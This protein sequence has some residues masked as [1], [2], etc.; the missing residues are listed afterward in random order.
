MLD[1][2]TDT[3][4]DE[5]L[6]KPD[7]KAVLDRTNLPIT[8]D[9]FLLPI[10]EAISNAID[11]AEA[12]HNSQITIAGSVSINF[13]HLNSPQDFEVR[14]VDNGIGLDVDNFRSFRTPFSGHKMRR[15]GRGF[16]RFIAFKVFEEVR[17]RSRAVS[18]GTTI[19]RNFRFD[20]Y[21][22]NELR[23]HDGEPEFPGSGLEVNLSHPLDVWA[24][25]IEGLTKQ[26]VLES[27]GSHFLGYFFSRA[28]P[29]ITIRFDEEQPID[30]ATEFKDRFSTTDEGSL[31]IEID[32][33]TLDVKY[34]LAR[35]PKSK[36]F[37][38]HAV[39]FTAAD[40]VVGRPR[41]ISTLVGAKH[42]SD[43]EGG[44]YVVIAV[45]SS[46]GF[47]SRLNHERTN[48][49]IPAN[50]IEEI[51]KAI[52]ERLNLSET[53]QLDKIK[54]QQCQMLNAAV[55]DSPILRL[56]LRGK[57]IGE[58]VQAKPNSWKVEQFVGDL[59]QH[60]YRRTRDLRKS[61]VAAA[62]DRPSYESAVRELSDEIDSGKKEALAEYIVHR[63]KIID[64]IDVARGFDD[65]GK[66]SPEDG[67]HELIFKRFADN[68]DTDFF[69]H[70][71]WLI[72]DALAFM[73]YIS[74][75]RPPD[76]KSRKKGDKVTDLL[77]YDDSMYLG[78]EAGTTLSI[79][80]FKRPNRNDYVFGKAK[81]DP[82]TQVIETIENAMD[83]GGFQRADGKFVSFDT[84]S[85]RTAFII[86][87]ITPTLKKVLRRQDFKN[88]A[89]PRIYTRY[90]DAEEIFIQV[91][92]YE[93]L[94][95]LAKKRNQAFFTVLMGE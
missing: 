89:D 19:N 54:T 62:V 57:T 76:G 94:I 72:D 91:M 3:G 34:R 36:Q 5:P 85:R 43:D 10:Y 84:V 16:G 40:R 53:Q 68:T 74:S 51:V 63:K 82:V 45:V 42:F 14:I 17:Y 44:K 28:L 11:G 13:F 75:D 78:E 87:D 88:L 7:M 8:A 90:R 95:E 31:P 71:L 2:K 60:R 48:L 18:Q 25:E 50:K 52:S 79:V 23:H 38:Y 58:Y 70:N 39:M 59:A 12:L 64:L 22:Q 35:V 65:A 77:F 26:L 49:A 55:Q 20:I 67:V 66:L 56:G 83:R 6:W 81:T 69:E 41:D 37:N 29:K 1:K 73:P 61:M 21:H 86:A 27:I 33:E 46:K 47:E 80:E 9:N 93:T 32:G 24:E 92:G 15:N 30:L 4:S